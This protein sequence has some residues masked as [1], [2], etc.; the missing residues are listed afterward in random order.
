MSKSKTATPATPPPPCLCQPKHPDDPGDRSLPVYPASTTD[1]EG[2]VRC[3][4][5]GGISIALTVDELTRRR[6][7][8]KA[9]RPAAAP[10][11]EAHGTRRE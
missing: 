1:P 6:V 4:A 2:I 5:C 7:A 9:A 8:A 11:P 3:D 10:A